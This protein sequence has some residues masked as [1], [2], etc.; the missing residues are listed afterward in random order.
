MNYI[1]K[2]IIVKFKNQDK[3]TY[4]FKSKYNELKMNPEVEIIIDADTDKIL[5]HNKGGSHK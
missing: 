1:F 5:Y 3:V 2:M 4:Y